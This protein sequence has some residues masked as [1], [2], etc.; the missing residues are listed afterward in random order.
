MTDLALSVRQPFAE[1]ILLGIKTL[2]VRGRHHSHQLEVAHA[3]L[4]RWLAG[5][6]R[7]NNPYRA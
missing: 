2:E 3:E 4:D 1:L 5:D 7:S 6:H